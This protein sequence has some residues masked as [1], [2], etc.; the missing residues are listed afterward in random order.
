MS[1]DLKTLPTPT[2]TDEGRRR[3]GI[4]V[5]L[6]GLPE[7]KVAEIL[8]QELGGEV[9][10]DPEKGLKV[11]GSA[12][13]DIEVYL[14]S[15][16]LYKLKSEL[17]EAVQNIARHVVPIEFVTGPIAPEDIP[18]LDAVMAALRAAGAT[19][20]SAGILLGFGVH[21]N[22]EVTGEGL[23]DVLPTLTAFALAEDAM[24]AE[25]QIDMSRRALPFVDPYPRKLIDALVSDPPASMEALIDLYLD[26]APSRNFALDMLSFFAH[27]DRDRVAAVMDMESISPRPTYHYRLP[28]CRIDEDGWDLALEWNR[29]AHIEDIAANAPLMKALKSAWR[30]HRAS[31]TTTRGDWA[32]TSARLIEEALA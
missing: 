29:W 2:T 15:R 8:R 4:E 26:L 28:D 3:V 18:R 27:V 31:L 19:G 7:A 16:P 9:R 1:R 5:E 22:P 25:M 10:K 30:V 17:G 20:T 21:L 23:G 32:K 13:G 24:R 12:I 6:G 14:D 11:C